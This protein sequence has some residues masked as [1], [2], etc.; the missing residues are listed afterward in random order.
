MK[1]DANPIDKNGFSVKFFEELEKEH[2]KSKD[3]ADRQKSLRQK[4]SQSAPR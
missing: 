2:A 1:K 3:M 4:H